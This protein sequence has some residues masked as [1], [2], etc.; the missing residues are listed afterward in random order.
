M[1]TQLLVPLALLFSL[2]PVSAFAKPPACERECAGQHVDRPDGLAF[3]CPCADE[4]RCGHPRDALAEVNA[5]RARRGL[6][7]FVRDEGLTRG[8]I[9]VARFRAERLIEGHTANDFAGLPRG[10][11]ASAAGCAA[12]HGDDW[13][14]C[15]TYERWRH[16]GAAWC[17]GRDGR[18]YMQLFVR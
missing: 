3:G 13:G 2:A 5:V 9:N 12:W 15:C 7:P 10:V 18:R 16:A 14:S 6:P 4:C 1:E 8:A 17:R 11:R